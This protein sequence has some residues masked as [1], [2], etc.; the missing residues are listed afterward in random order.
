MIWIWWSLYIGFS[1]SLIN[2]RFSKYYTGIPASILFIVHKYFGYQYTFPT[3]FL[4]EL[5]LS[6]FDNFSLFSSDEEKSSSESLFDI[7]LLPENKKVEEQPQKIIVESQ[8]AVQDPEL[9]MIKFIV[10]TITSYRNQNIL[11]ENILSE[12]YRTNIKIV[13]SNTSLYNFIKS[14]AQKLRLKNSVTKLNISG[15]TIN[16]P[17]SQTNIEWMN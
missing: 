1:Y 12:I 6:V 8:P 5:L 3:L 13:S 16:V 15:N 2:N 7:E 4:M 9:D 14:E 11:T 10:S 17:H